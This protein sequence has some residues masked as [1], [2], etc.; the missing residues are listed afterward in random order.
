MEDQVV[1]PLFRHFTTFLLG[2]SATLF[3]CENEI[4]ASR[5]FLEFRKSV[6]SYSD[7]M[8][9]MLA[10]NTKCLQC[11]YIHIL[12]EPESDILGWPCPYTLWNLILFLL[13][14]NVVGHFILMLWKQEIKLWV[15]EGSANWTE[16]LNTRNFSNFDNISGLPGREVLWKCILLMGL[17]FPSIFESFLKEINLI[18]GHSQPCSLH[19]IAATRDKVYTCN[20]S[21]YLIIWELYFL[22]PDLTFFLRFFE[23][24]CMKSAFMVQRP[25]KLFIHSDTGPPRG[26]WKESYH[27][28]KT[29][30]IAMIVTSVYK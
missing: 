26:R 19:S 29:Q 17:F 20:A 10:Q 5:A 1:F 16:A 18:S 27:L 4:R 22:W 25:K 21:Y 14:I 9:K 24:V 7:A 3:L 13:L 6:L 12:F 30:C 15:T 2:L 23:A 28:K 11:K 8:T